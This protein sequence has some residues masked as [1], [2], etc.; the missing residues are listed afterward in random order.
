MYGPK[1]VL[2]VRLPKCVIDLLIALFYC[3]ITNMKVILSARK[4][5]IP[6]K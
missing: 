6:L 5:M 3:L 2:E 1:F 4:T